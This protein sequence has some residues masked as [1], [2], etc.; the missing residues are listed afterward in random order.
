MS[1][2]TRIYEE[3]HRNARRTGQQRR[4]DLAGGA[5][6]SVRV[7]AGQ[8]TLTIGRPGKPLSDRE[9]AVFVAHCAVPATAQRYPPLTQA[10][11]EVRGT[12]WHLVAY[13]WEEEEP[14]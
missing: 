5:R 10:Q 6:L 2:I 12:T 8:T 7:D 3:L 1:A 13:R 4:A 14:T 11:R 9:L